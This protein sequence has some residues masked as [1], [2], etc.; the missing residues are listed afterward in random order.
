MILFLM[1]ESNRGPTEM[2]ELPLYDQLPVRPGLPAGSSW[3]LWGDEDY[4]GCLNL[5]SPDRVK[6]AVAEVQHG[7]VFPLNHDLASPSPPLF[8]RSTLSHQVHWIDDGF[9]HDD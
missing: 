6:A 2:S 7:T 1:N 9:G 4:L 8:G 3:G 5:L